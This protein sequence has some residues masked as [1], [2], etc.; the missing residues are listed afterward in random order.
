ML[1]STNYV[2]FAYYKLRQSVVT[3]Y[4]SFFY[5]KLSFYKLRHVFQITTKLEIRFRKNLAKLTGSAVKKMPKGKI[6]RRA[7]ARE[8][9]AA[10][11]HG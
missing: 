3:N 9:R 10:E 7:L 4:D 1:I 5:Y 2:S 11:L 6:I 8:A